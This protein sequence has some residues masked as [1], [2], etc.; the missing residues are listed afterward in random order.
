M[1][2]DLFYIE[3]IFITGFIS[4]ITGV[5]TGEVNELVNEPTGIE[6]GLRLSKTSNISEASQTIVQNEEE[7]EF[8]FQNIAYRVIGA[9]ICVSL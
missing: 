4:K 2:Y 7:D 8:G 1:T 9:A 3:K 5:I 6:N